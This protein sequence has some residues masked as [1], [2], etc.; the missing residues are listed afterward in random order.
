MLNSCQSVAKFS[1]YDDIEAKLFDLYFDALI[2]NKL[3][4][5]EI[6]IEIGINLEKF[7]QFYLEKLYENK[8]IHYY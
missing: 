5:V 1:V 8:V 4:L 3:K 2:R 7:N 6:Y